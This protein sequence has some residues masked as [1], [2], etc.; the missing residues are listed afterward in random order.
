MFNVATIVNQLF[1]TRLGIRVG[2]CMP[3]ANQLF[4][5][6]LG[7]RVVLCMPTGPVYLSTSYDFLVFAYSREL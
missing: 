5:T 1:L 4:L 6:R 7:I 2:F 3:R